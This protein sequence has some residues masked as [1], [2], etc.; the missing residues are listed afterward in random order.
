MNRGADGVHAV[1][2]VAPW[3]PARKVNVAGLGGQADDAEHRRAGNET[4]SFIV[5]TPSSTLKILV[6]GA[7]TCWVS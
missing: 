1:V 6:A 4:R 3:R 5:T 2:H 7:W